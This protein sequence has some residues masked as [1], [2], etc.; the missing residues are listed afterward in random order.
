MEGVEEAMK[1]SR[2]EG[3]E[4]PRFLGRCIQVWQEHLMALALHSEILSR[5]FCFSEA[6][7]SS[8]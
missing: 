4:D 6:S 7:V 5:S 1:R 3:G 8:L 2:K